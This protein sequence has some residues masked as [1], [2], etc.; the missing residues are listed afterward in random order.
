MQGWDW[1][2]AL[3]LGLAVNPYSHANLDL[4]VRV[5]AACTRLLQ[6]ADCRQGE[7]NIDRRI[8]THEHRA[9]DSQSLDESDARVILFL[10]R[11][12][13]HILSPQRAYSVSAP[14]LD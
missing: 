7:L 14:W 8:Q 6:T 4:F 12:Y 13:S 1:E 11:A 5:A 10:S 2:I 9:I 3:D